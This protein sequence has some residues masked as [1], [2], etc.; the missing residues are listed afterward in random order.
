MPIQIN[1]LGLLIL[2]SLQ[3]LDFYQCIDNSLNPCLAN[4]EKFIE[5]KT[6]YLI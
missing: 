4:L 1:I 3:F 5:S 6:K 2:F